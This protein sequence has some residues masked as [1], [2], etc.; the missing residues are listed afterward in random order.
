MTD[1]KWIKVAVDMFE[2]SKIEFLRSMPEGDSIIVIWL[3]MLSIAGK[4][5]ADGYLMITEGVPYT[6]QLLCNTLRRNPVLMQFALETFK[7]LKMVNMEDGPFHIT[8]WEKHQNAEQMSK[9]KSDGAIRQARYRER[10]KEKILLMEKCN[11]SDVTVTS[12]SDIT[13]TLYN[14]QEV[15]SK[16]KEKHIDVFSEYTTNQELIETLNAFVEFRKTIKAKMTDRA[17][18]LMLGELNRLANTDHE[19]IAILNQSILNNY[20]GVFALKKPLT[21]ISNNPKPKA[22]ELSEADKELLQRANG[23]TSA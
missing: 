11:E 15:R 22:F 4:S 5:N 16:N 8:K 6:E 17:I 14:E 18:K 9:I 13:K 12:R 21:V 3:Q 7:K 20:K 10:Q 19:K 1:I 23:S 2:D